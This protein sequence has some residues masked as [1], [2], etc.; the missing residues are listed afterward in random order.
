[1]SI[2]A[3]Q[4]DN[5]CFASSKEIAKLFDLALIGVR[6]FSADTAGFE[7]IPAGR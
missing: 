5:G 4:L 3:S 7:V 6:S 1:M 2:S